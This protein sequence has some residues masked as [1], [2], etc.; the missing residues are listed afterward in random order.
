MAPDLP[1]SSGGNLTWSTLIW[2]SASD[3]VVAT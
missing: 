1:K 3:L 2:L